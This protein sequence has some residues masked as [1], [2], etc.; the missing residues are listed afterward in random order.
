MIYDVALAGGNPVAVYAAVE[1][2]M[3]KGSRPTVRVKTGDDR[4]APN[5]VDERGPFRDHFAGLLGGTAAAFCDLVAGERGVFA[6]HG[7]SSDCRVVSGQSRFVRG[8]PFPTWTLV[9]CGNWTG[10]LPP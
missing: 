8:L 5:Y 2:F 6:R 1:D 10:G 7:N 9:D 3:P 4:S